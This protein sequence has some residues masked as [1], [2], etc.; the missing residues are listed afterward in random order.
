MTDSAFRVLL[1]EDN[2]D[3]AEL[4]REPWASISAR[5]RLCI[6]AMVRALSITCIVAEPGTTPTKAPAPT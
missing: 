4:I 3:H 5:H 1:V 2:D 6:S